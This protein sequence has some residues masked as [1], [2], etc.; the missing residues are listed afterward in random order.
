MREMK[1]YYQY[2][3]VA[4]AP[5]RIFSDPMYEE[6][7]KEEKRRRLHARNARRRAHKR[8]LRAARLQLF[9]LCI[10]ILMV[11]SMLFGS[12]YLQTRVSDEK[13]AISRLEDEFAEITG[14]NA[15]LKSRIDTAINLNDIRD[16]AMGLGMV[17][18]GNEH[19]VYYELNN[20]DYMVSH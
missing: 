13:K 11:G 12:V 4:Q 18:A 15:A 19:V 20:T 7:K 3:S 16:I 2:G 1:R 9:S 5:E 17:Y 8:S 10:G 6:R 14:R